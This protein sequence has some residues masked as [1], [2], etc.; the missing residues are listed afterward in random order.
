[1]GRLLLVVTVLPAFALLLGAV[2]AVG[3]RYGRSMTGG[4]AARRTVERLAPVL[5]AGIVAAAALIAAALTGFDPR[6]LGLWAREPLGTGGGLLLGAAVV[7]G[8][9]AGAVG[10][11]G[12]LM[13]S[14]RVLTRRFAGPPG[15]GDPAVR[16]GGGPA[17]H[18]D[19]PPATAAG[20]AAPRPARGEAA[21]MRAAGAWASSPRGLLALG[22][23]TAV[24]EEVLFRG[25][26]LTGLREAVPLGA[27]LVLQALLFGV[28][29]ASFGLSAV[30]A[31]AVHGLVWGALTVAAG[32]LLPAL[33]AHLV[34]QFLACRRMTRRK[35]VDTP[36]GGMLDDGAHGTAAV[37]R[38]PLVG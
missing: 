37:R 38:P 3:M 35:G 8:A 1:M 12:E 5:Y 34:F 24:A 10:Y 33:T 22:L 9:V 36:E 27:A 28:H 4:R 18:T 30:P 7:G 23:V 14:Q 32:T 2:I 17:A 13:L 15:A 11:I 25:Y 20:R 29:H 19:T 16:P 6:A 31:K 21:G 26:L